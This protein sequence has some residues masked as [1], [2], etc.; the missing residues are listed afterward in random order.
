M[1]IGS[2]RQKLSIGV[3][4]VLLLT[5]LFFL[6]NGTRP[7]DK[8][9]FD[10][11]DVG[12]MHAVRED[13]KGINVTVTHPSTAALAKKISQFNGI[14]ELRILGEATREF[15]SDLDEFES[16]IELDMRRFDVQL[17]NE[18]FSLFPNVKSLAIFDNVTYD[19]RSIQLL[20]QCEE[21]DTDMCPITDQSAQNIL[22]LHK[23]KSVIILDD[24]NLKVETRERFLNATEFDAQ[25]GNE[26]NGNEANE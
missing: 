8:S 15:V 21:I 7:I 25:I 23:L 26:Y 10:Q 18:I 20:Q 13:G 2:Q 11:H 4:V 12:F 9:S 17:S 22:K 19:G 3:G 5:L 14:V 24:T 16:V 6:W 1:K